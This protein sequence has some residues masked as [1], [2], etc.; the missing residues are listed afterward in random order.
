M[1]VI[2]GMNAITAYQGGVRNLKDLMKMEGAM[3][4]SRTFGSVE[5]NNAF[6]EGVQILRRVDPVLPVDDLI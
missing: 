6:L 3:I 1:Q 5:E 4:V 2:Y